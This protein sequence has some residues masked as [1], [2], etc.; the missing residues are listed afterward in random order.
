[1]SWHIQYWERGADCFVRY[2]SPESAIEAACLLMD[3]G[4]DVYGI[5]SGPVA[6]SIERE[7]IGRIYEFWA[8]G[9]Y[10]FRQQR[11]IPPRSS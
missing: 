7:Q 8:R 1:M 3:K 2:P 5:G 6:N 9:K 10:P 11:F 4:C